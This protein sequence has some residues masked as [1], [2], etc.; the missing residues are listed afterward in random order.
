M[1][2]LSQVSQRAPW[3][4]LISSM[5]A[6]SLGAEVPGKLGRHRGVLGNHL[7]VDSPTTA[8]VQRPLIFPKRPSALCSCKA[9]M[10]NFM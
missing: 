8:I 9:T 3:L 10:F 5:L 6:S 7:A 1:L 4:R 2:I